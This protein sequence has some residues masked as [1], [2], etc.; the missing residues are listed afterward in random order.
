MGSQIVGI[1]GRK[2]L[3]SG[4]L[5]MKRFVVKEVITETTVVLLI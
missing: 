3:A 2:M 5:K 1:L 4:I